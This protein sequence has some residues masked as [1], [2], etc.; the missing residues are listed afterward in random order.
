MISNLDNKTPEIAYPCEWVMKIIGS[1]E[2]AMREVITSIMECRH[3]EIAHSNTSKTGK[4]ISLKVRLTFLS[5]EEKQYIYAKF[6]A[7]KVIKFV[8]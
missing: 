1:D 2:K 6:T 3:Y 4:Y 7:N 8:L 5:A